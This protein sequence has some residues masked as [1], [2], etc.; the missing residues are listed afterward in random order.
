MNTKRIICL[1][2][3]TLLISTLLVAQANKWR[4]VL[5]GTQN[6]SS[7]SRFDNVAQD[8]TGY[9]WFGAGNGLN[10]FDGINVKI[11]KS[12]L[13]DS[14]TIPDNT[15]NCI[16]SDS[17]GN[18][19]I[20]TS[21]GVCIYNRIDDNFL[22]IKCLENISIRTIIEDSNH[23]YWAAS[24][25]EGLFCLSKD[26]AILKQISAKKSNYSSL[27][28]NSIWSIFEDKQGVIWIG[29]QSGDICSYDPNSDRFI[30]YSGKH[31]NGSIL[32]FK[33]LK[34]ENILISS[35][36]SG[37]L[38]L[39]KKNKKI[40]KNLALL[41][42]S[43]VLK[44]S[45]LNQPVAKFFQGINN[46]YWF[47]YDSGFI[48]IDKNK[49][50]ELS[51]VKSPFGIP[52]SYSLNEMTFDNQ[53]N[54]WFATFQDG[55]VLMNKLFKKFR[56]DYAQLFY[57]K[58]LISI[59][60]DSKGNLWFGTDGKGL[61]YINKKTNQVKNYS[62]TNASKYGLNEHSVFA[63]CETKE[64]EIYVG[65]YKGFYVFDKKKEKFIGYYHNAD[66]PNS[67]SN[68][69][70]RDIIEDDDGNLWI[71]TCGGGI[72][73]FNKKT[74][75]FSKLKQNE[76]NPS[77]GIVNNY[78]L[79]L[80]KDTK[81]NIWIGTY[82]GFTKCN[83]KENKF[84]NITNSKKYILSNNWIYKILEDSNGN[85]WLA[86]NN[87]VDLYN[88]VTNKF[89]Y[90]F[91][92]DGLSDNSIACILE[93]NNKDIWISTAKGLNKFDVK[94]QKFTSF[95]KSDDLPITQF[96]HGSGFKNKK[97]EIFF[98][99]HG[100]YT[101]FNPN[102]IKKNPFIP[103]VII[104]D[105]KL[106]NSS[107]EI[108]SK[109][110]S[111]LKHHISYT[112]EITLSYDQN[113]ITIEYIAFNYLNPEKN[114]FAYKLRGFDDNW[115]YVGTKRDVTYTNL[116]PGTYIFYVKAS[117]DDGI[118]NNIPTQLIIHITPPWWN[119]WW[120]LI[121]FILLILLCIY[122]YIIYREKSLKDQNKALDE[123]V[124][125]RTAQ[126]TKQNEEIT[127]QKELLFEQ[128]LELNETNTL[129]E[130]RQQHV[131]EQAEE[132]T[133]QRDK[134][135]ELNAT[136]DKF[137]SIIA[138]DLRG[139]I[140]TLVQ[141]VQSFHTRYER[142]DDVKRK[143]Y[144][145]SINNSLNKVYSLLLN[146]LEWSR[147]Q[148]DLIEFNPQEISALELIQQNIDILKET[149]DKKGVIINLKV[150]PG[151]FSIFV[152]IN[153]LQTILRNLISNAIKFTQTNG[154]ILI[155]ASQT[156]EGTIFSVADTGIG[157][158]EENIEKLFRIDQHI[159]TVGTNN[160]AGT[161]LGLILCKEFVEKHNGKIWVKSILDEGTEFS[162]FIPK[163]FEHKNND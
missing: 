117:N 147:S 56:S 8:T 15:I 69:D 104:T 114:K 54:A 118:W 28:N 61:Y 66:N 46:N 44:N 64:K 33:E 120:A 125:E 149:A 2:I 36:N 10:R 116:N 107:V 16:I 29:T 126:I 59:I 153:L 93:D 92:K 81:G 87:G 138:H 130:E 20:A 19:I 62:Y 52:I 127:I 22:R 135:Q 74:H 139:P 70:V 157:I 14:T 6:G 27:N 7:S 76:K 5:Y 3:I 77:K 160:E 75:T 146:L 21:K 40:N 31:N 159:S 152:D 101:Y 111:I 45:P 53:D 142:F 11:Y 34:N 161:G 38:L 49:V 128:T 18:L 88:P 48:S 63:I 132:I 103:K 30:N 140:G 102:E 115:R 85:I 72:N 67:I 91:E 106:F 42:D 105:L 133:A 162:F 78:C 4:M 39:D 83:L 154:K 98:C 60:E 1:G 25:G 79:T 35:F 112:K 90:F 151:N 124:K 37:L 131:E 50:L 89:K 65:T 80:L 24:Q 95:S 99:G 57:N 100:G 82:D 17:K 148:R 23:K 97:G 58:V 155:K 119:T 94:E 71:A 43:N 26:F 73:I 121:G 122:L 47:F 158:K 113:V 32:S 136:K 150:E 86:T 68:N 129:L 134:L 41:L 12:S 9:M 108:S 156:P 110:N 144:I 51:S 141:F 55:I 109:S 123:K 84:L 96:S 145:E 137:F 163:D 143:Y 13:T